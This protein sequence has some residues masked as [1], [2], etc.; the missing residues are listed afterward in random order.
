MIPDKCVQHR[1]DDPARV[2]TRLRHVDESNALAVGSQRGSQQV[3]VR[4]RDGY[5]SRL[6]Q[7]E[8]L[9][10]ETRDGDAVVVRVTVEQR[11]VHK[12]GVSGYCCARGP[13]SSSV[14]SQHRASP[15]RLV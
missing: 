3:K 13:T 15:L 5:Q 10:K 7:L 11:L 12:A 2:A 1:A 4:S 8:A 14:V 6:R 9:L